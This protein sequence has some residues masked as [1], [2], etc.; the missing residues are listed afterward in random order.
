MHCRDVLRELIAYDTWA[1]RRIL[2]ALQ[3]S[4]ENAHAQRVF[5]HLLATQQLWLE[6]IEKGEGATAEPWPD[7]EPQ[8]FADQID[9]NHKALLALISATSEDMLARPITYRNTKGL[10]FSTPMREI[11]V[12]VMHHGTHHRAQVAMILKE[13]GFAPPWVDFIVF[14]RERRGEGA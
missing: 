3:A 4:D 6:R 11:L 7:P 8:G 1:N 2:E 13:S 12:H 5:G 9:A 10:G 14:V